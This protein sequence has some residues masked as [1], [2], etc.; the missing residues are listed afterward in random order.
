MA[1]YEFSVMNQQFNQMK[2]MCEQ[3]IVLIDKEVASDD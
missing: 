2:A 3:L 1:V